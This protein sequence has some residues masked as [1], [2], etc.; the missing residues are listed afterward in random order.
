MATTNTAPFEVIAAP[1]RV[2]IAEVGTEFPGVDD[3][4]GASPAFDDW[5]LVGTSGDLNYDRGA[6]VVVEH[7]QTMSPWRSVGDAGSRK[8]FRTEEDL[9]IKLKLVDITLEQYR[10]AMNN[11]AVDSSETGSRKI[12]LSRGFSVAT[13]A[14]LIRSDVSPYGDGLNMQYEIP[15]AAQS[16]NPSVS[17]SKPGEPAALDLEWMALVDPDATDPSER[18]GRLVAQDGTT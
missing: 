1:Y 13:F 15:R 14:V 10:H 17:L 6:G 3:E 16:G 8:V 5:G 11:N 9:K 4:E 2:Y 7:S 18:F 12:G